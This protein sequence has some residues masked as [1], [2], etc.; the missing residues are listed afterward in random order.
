MRSNPV[1]CLVEGMLDRF[2]QELDIEGRVIATGGFA[3]VIAPL[4][5][6]LP[7]VDQLLTLDGIRLIADQNR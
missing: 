1:S 6:K 3:S 7:L 5:T 4:T 2:A